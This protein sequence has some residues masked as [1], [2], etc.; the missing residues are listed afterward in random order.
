[1]ATSLESL[2]QSC[3]AAE[4][5]AETLKDMTA[6]SFITKEVA[7]VL[8]A[9]GLEA[10]QG[11]LQTIPTRHTL[12]GRGRLLAYRCHRNAWTF[13]ASMPTGLRA[14]GLRKR[15]L[16][17]SFTGPCRTLETRENIKMILVAENEHAA[18]NKP[19]SN[20]IN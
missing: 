9:K 20:E 7:N 6:N 13:W 10:I 11:T 4:T 14:S 16:D 12:E 1:M 3:L 2:L 15:N 18:A 8:Y 17:G 19:P 5:L